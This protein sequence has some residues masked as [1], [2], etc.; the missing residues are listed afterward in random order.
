MLAFIDNFAIPF[1][2]SLYGAVG[3]VGVMI[4]MAIESAMIPLQSIVREA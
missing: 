2:T 1:L 3:Y 4:A